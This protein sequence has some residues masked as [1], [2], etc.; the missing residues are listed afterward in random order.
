MPNQVIHWEILSKDPKRA[1]D[2]FSQLFDWHVDVMEEFNYG[3]VDTHGEGGI[4][5]GIG[6]H[7]EEGYRVTLYVQVDDLQESL[8]TAEK[9]GGKTVMPPTEIP[10]MVTLAQFSD[11]DGNIIGLI[12]R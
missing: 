8:D 5:G 11:P 9:L 4:N 7:Q 10:G 1:Q 6:G 2:F 3:I 12:K